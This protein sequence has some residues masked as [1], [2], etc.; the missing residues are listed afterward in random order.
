M[1]VVRELWLLEVATVRD[2]GVPV[3]V[4]LVGLRDGRWWLVDTGCPADMIGVADAPFAVTAESH[5]SGQL[6][7]LGVLDIDTVI[8]SHLDPDHA[9]A[10]DAFPNA[11][12]VIQ[13]AQHRHATSSGLLRYEWMRQH[14]D[15][16]RWELVDGD[17]ELTPG[18]TL[19]ECGGHVPGHQAVLL[20]LP[21]TGAVLLAGDAWMRDTDP[22]TR[23]ITQHDLDEPE[24]RA[25]QRKL[26]TLAEQRNVRLVVHNHDLEQWRTLERRYT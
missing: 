18:I 15:A 20:E 25:S 2:N 1:T 21:D 7:R 22:A 19:I 13:R 5:I 12:F 16:S 8:V 6:A 10:H 9:G 11:R 23:P 24:V 4:F 26:M 17:T 14:W 3:P